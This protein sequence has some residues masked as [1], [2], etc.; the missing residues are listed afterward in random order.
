MKLV[1]TALVLALLAMAVTAVEK[2]GKTVAILGGGIGGL[3]AA[4]ELSDRGYDVSV[5]ERGTLFGG[6]ARSIPFEGS[7]KDGRDDLPGEHGFR[8]CM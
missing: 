3:T 1:S 4:I 6:K 5:Y 2:N 7:G 8:F